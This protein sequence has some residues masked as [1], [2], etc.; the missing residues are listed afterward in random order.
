MPTDNNSLLFGKWEIADIHVEDPGVKRY[1]HFDSPAIHT[2]GRHAH[3][4][5]NK[6]NL[7]IVERLT[8]KLMRGE[9]NTGKK[10]KAYGT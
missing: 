3:H 5:F 9:G 1:V 2:G 4:Q 7:S 8:N 10:I 6:S